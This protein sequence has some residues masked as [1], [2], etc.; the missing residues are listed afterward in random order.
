MLFCLFVSP[1]HN[2]CHNRPVWSGGF[3]QLSCLTPA[4]KWCR[5]DDTRSSIRFYTFSVYFLSSP[6]FFSLFFTKFLL[7][8]V[9]RVPPIEI[10]LVL[11]Y[12]IAFLSIQTWRRYSFFR[13]YW[14]FVAYFMHGGFFLSR[15][16]VNPREN[17]WEL[18]HSNIII[19]L[20]FLM[21][22]LWNSCLTFKDVLFL[23]F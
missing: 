11:A 4:P 17:S 15:C 3:K 21:P 13:Y 8:F 6:V 1:F 7:A 22:L 5:S 14:T 2:E 23:N 12:Q 10:V 16:S 19:V 20:S 9:W 18:L